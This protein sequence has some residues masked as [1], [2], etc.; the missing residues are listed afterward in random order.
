MK[1]SPF[2]LRKQVNSDIIGWDVI[3]WSNALYFWE[4]TS[5][6]NLSN[7]Y[8]LELGAGFSGGLSLWLTLKGSR[9]VCSTKGSILASVIA[10]HRKYQL[11]D[12]IEYED[13]DILNMAYNE[14][15]E[16]IMLKSVLGGLNGS[17]KLEKQHQAIAQIYKSLKPGGEFLFAENIV[18]TP[19]HMYLRNRYGSGGKHSWQYFSANEML[20]II[21]HRFPDCQFITKGF[22]ACFGR[23]ENQRKWLG[24]IDQLFFS[25][26]IPERFRYIIIGVAR[27]S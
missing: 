6:H 17:P 8:A 3:N 19:L 5:H 26:V 16:L 2:S 9:V 13:V 20:R 24:I 12:K 18:S 15:F 11:Q 25:H 10:C 1:S 22:I 23:N 21:S 4:K 27:K 7:S 14:K